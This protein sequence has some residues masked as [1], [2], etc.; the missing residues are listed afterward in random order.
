MNQI[1]ATS[2]LIAS[3]T[4]RR[5]KYVLH[6]ALLIGGEYKIM[7]SNILH[8]WRTKITGVGGGFYRYFFVRYKENVDIKTAVF[9]VQHETWQAVFWNQLNLWLSSGE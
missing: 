3:Q 8:F 6:D 5:L 7:K 1:L 9:L 2:F 4:L